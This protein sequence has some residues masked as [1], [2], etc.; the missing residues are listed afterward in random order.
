MIP[1]SRKAANPGVV[2]RLTDRLHP[3]LLDLVAHRTLA[4]QAAAGDAQVLR[5]LPRVRLRIDARLAE[6]RLA[7]P[8]GSV[9]AFFVGELQRRWRLLRMRGER[10]DSDPDAPDHLFDAHTRLID[11]LRRHARER[12]QD[13]QISGVRR[14]AALE[15]IQDALTQMGVLCTSLAAIVDSE[16]S[17]RAGAS[18]RGALLAL[19]D[20]CLENCTTALTIIGPRRNPDLDPRIA[21]ALADVQEVLEARLDAG[22]APRLQRDRLM[23]LPGALELAGAEIQL[24]RRECLADLAGLHAQAPV[25]LSGVVGLLVAAT[26]GLCQVL[27]RHVPQLAASPRAAEPVIRETLR[28]A[29]DL[30]LYLDHFAEDH[31]DADCARVPAPSAAVDEELT[32]LFDGVAGAFSRCAGR[33]AL[34]L[35]DL[36]ELAE[37]ARAVADEGR[38]LAMNARLDA[39]CLG[40][41]D[42]PRTRIATEVRSF[43]ARLADSAVGLRLLLEGL[44][45]DAAGTRITHPWTDGADGADDS[46]ALAQLLAAVAPAPGGLGGT[47]FVAL[48]AR[49][50]GSVDALCQSCRGLLAG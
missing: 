33:D 25:R 36:F 17:G 10:L 9:N 41:F 14:L 50:R 26:S 1:T 44:T 48:R 4:T 12:D 21:R 2:R 40:D 8:P 5:L 39:T 19:L 30:G 49:L 46:A 13:A 34:T 43:A 3:V 45:P 24:E 6:T 29:E 7:M 28:I 15:T 16:T 23:A 32:R 31:P 27:L 47:D 42:D 11:L 35:A 38:R 22:P 18:A 37:Q 20:T